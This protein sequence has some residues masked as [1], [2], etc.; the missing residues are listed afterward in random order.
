ME[1]IIQPKRKNLRKHVQDFFAPQHLVLQAMLIPAL[2]ALILFSYLP[3][4]GIIISVKEYTLGKGFFDGKWVG[5]KYFEQVL[6]DETFWRAA[7]N[8]I[9]ISSLH[10]LITFPAPIILALMFNESSLHRIKK[11]SQT[12]SYLP[13]FLSMVVVASFWQLILGNNGLVNNVLKELGMITQSIA[14]WTTPEYYYP[15]ELL[16]SLWKGTG[17]SAIIYFSAITNVSEEVYE[18]AVVDGAGRFRRVFSIVLPCII[19]T[20]AVNW[21]MSI[22]GLFRGSF[23]TSYL[24]GNAFNRDVSYVLEYYITETGLSR[25][26]YSYA[27]AIGQIQSVVSLVLLFAANALSKRFADTSIF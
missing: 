13:N 21:I 20:I 18:A 19:P 9:V 23:D 15:L 5:L 7:R 22:S 2:L 4:S 24:L 8:T 14:F 26:R 3:M 17:W 6:S 10:M 16:V 1:R 27:T 25:L 12:C 11:I